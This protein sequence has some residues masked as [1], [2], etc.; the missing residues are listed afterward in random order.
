MT[1]KFVES[2]RPQTIQIEQDNS[3]RF[4]Q[5]RAIRHNIFCSHAEDQ[6]TF[7]KYPGSNVA[8]GISWISVEK[9]HFEVSEQRVNRVFA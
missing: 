2:K 6:T 1:G 5:D 7:L 3:F 4:I 9:R 8:L